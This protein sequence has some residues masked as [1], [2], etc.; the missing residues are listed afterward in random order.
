MSASVNIAGEPIVT[1]GSSSTLSP[2]TTLVSDGLPPPPYG[3]SHV[4]PPTAPPT[5]SNPSQPPPPYT[6]LP[7]PTTTTIKSRRPK[8]DTKTVISAILLFTLHLAVLLAF[9]GFIGYQ[10][11]RRV[12][13]HGRPPYSMVVLT[14]FVLFSL[15]GLLFLAFLFTMVAT[16]CLKYEWWDWALY[17]KIQREDDV[18]NEDSDDDS[19]RGDAGCGPCCPCTQGPGA[20]WFRDAGMAGGGDACAACLCGIVLLAVVAAFVGAIW[21]VGFSY[22]V[23]WRVCW[24]I[25]S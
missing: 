3:G 9:S 25:V 20:L 19:Q 16:G 12:V 8:N 17:G 14:G 24:K 21:V 2:T 15:M 23:L 18:E 22:V 5:P 10:F 6:T 4:Y 13:Y 7:L 11:L 1:L